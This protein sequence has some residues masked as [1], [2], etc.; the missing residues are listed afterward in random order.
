MRTVCAAEV[1]HATLLR[2]EAINHAAGS[3]SPCHVCLY[4]NHKVVSSRALSYIYLSI[5][6]DVLHDGV[7]VSLATVALCP[8]EALP[9]LDRHHRK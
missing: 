9:H 8:A 2:E 4:M 5:V 3:R 6:M 1:W 7:R